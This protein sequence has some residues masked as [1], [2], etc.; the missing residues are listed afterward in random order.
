MWNRR[1]FEDWVDF[2]KEEISDEGFKSIRKENGSKG[3]KKKKTWMRKFDL[4]AKFMRILL[5]IKG[6]KFFGG[7]FSSV[8]IKEFSLYDVFWNFFLFAKN[9]CS[10]KDSPFERRI[11][12]KEGGERS[13]GVFLIKRARILIFNKSLNF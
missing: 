12:F 7:L 3:L 11:N 1:R 4:G 5:K 2:E 13:C 8:F 10:Q 9:V 6:S